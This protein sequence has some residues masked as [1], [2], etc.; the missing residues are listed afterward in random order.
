MG[1]GITLDD[2]S[3]TVVRVVPAS[4]DLQVSNFRTAQVY[5]PLGQWK[6]P[7]LA[8]RGAGLGFH[9]I[10]RLKDGITIEQARADMDRV[11]HNLAAIYPDDKEIGAK[12]NP[13][14][15]EMV[16]RIRPVLLVL[17]AAVAVVLLI[18]CV[19]VANLLLAR[20]TSRSREFAIRAAVGASQS[21]MVRQLLAESMVLAFIGGG[22]G[23]LLAG[24]GIKVA[25]PLSPTAL[26]RAQEIGFDGSVLLFTIFT[27]LATGLLFG[28]APAVRTL[29]TNLQSTLQEGGRG[30]VSG[31]QRMQT[32]FVVME[33]AMA[34]VLLIGAGLSIRSLIRLWSVDPGF[35]PQNVLTFRFSWPSMAKMNPERTRALFREYDSRLQAVPGV[36]AVSQSGAAIP[37]STDDERLFWIDGQPKPASQSEMNWEL[38]YIVEPD[39][40]KVM[41]IPLLLGRF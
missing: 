33:I 35:D 5:L 30:L 1:K 8:N 41:R 4:F 17:L 22:L 6:N 26:P 34:L 31:R 36:M 11:T 18:A 40:L 14:N 29:Q 2:S 38:H 13:F 20:S 23:L 28:L 9:G 10:G 12:V 19:N 25:V 27:C 7:I 39:Y 37:L 24:W 3:Y 32:V 15:D 16:G 21:R